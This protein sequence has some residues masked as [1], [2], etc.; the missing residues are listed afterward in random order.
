MPLRVV[1]DFGFDVTFRYLACAF[2]N[3]HGETMK[4][5][6]SSSPCQG[7]KNKIWCPGEMAPSDRLHFATTGAISLLL[8]AV[9]QSFVVFALFTAYA[10]SSSALRLSLPKNV[11]KC[12]VATFQPICLRRLTMAVIL[13]HYHPDP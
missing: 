9:S 11:S 8:T 3:C 5:A 12:Q 4:L 10:W 2:V 13:N 6:S 1:S 7:K